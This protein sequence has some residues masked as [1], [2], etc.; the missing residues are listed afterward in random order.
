MK[1]TL[2]SILILV[3]IGCI[4]L[5]SLTASILNQKPVSRVE[6][7]VVELQ[8]Q[9]LL[10]RG[11]DKLIRTEIRY[12]VVTDKE[13]FICQSSLLNGKFKNSDI[14]WR[15]QKDST[16]SFTVVG[17]GKTAFTK[18]RNIIAVN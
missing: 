1:K 17:M 6:G 12:L 7:K 9:Q 3:A 8:Q 11:S 18:Y 5:G 15:L 4:G 16:Y 14:F 13:T 2:F 10:K